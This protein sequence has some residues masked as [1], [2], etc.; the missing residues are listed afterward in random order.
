ML[1]PVNPQLSLVIVKG[2]MMNKCVDI[3][4]ANANLSSSVSVPLSLDCSPSTMNR[5][6]HVATGG[7]GYGSFDV[8]FGEVEHEERAILPPFCASFKD[9]VLMWPLMAILVVLVLL[10]ASDWKSTLSKA[11]ELLSMSRRMQ[12]P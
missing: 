12:M 5:N 2:V 7:S 3:H 11:T 9:A 4:M 10:G 1:V 6:I 8:E